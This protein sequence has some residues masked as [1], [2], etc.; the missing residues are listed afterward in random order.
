M[1]DL[2]AGRGPKINRL[3]SALLWLA[4]FML[5]ASHGADPLGA[6]PLAKY[7]VIGVGLIAVV[8]SIWLQRRSERRVTQQ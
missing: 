5:L 6:P 7:A 1:T 4:I 3:A 8:S 2:Q